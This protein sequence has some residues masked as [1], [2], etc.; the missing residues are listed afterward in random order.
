M[1]ARA[2]RR[3]PPEARAG[4]LVLPPVAPHRTLKARNVNF[5]GSR[6][7]E[8]RTYGLRWRPLVRA[9]LNGATGVDPTAGGSGP[10][11]GDAFARTRPGDRTPASPSLRTSARPHQ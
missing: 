7:R 11:G 10:L 4:T 1:V 9:S 6:M 2:G 8:I 5:E 3:P